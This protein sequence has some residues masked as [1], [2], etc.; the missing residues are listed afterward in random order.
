MYTS[1][2]E[3]DDYTDRVSNETLT[4]GTTVPLAQFY[5]RDDV[6][7]WTDLTTQEAY[8]AF[9]AGLDVRRADVTIGAEIENIQ[10]L[11]DSSYTPCIITSEEG[12]RNMGLFGEKLEKAEIYL[13]GTPD[14]ETEAWL[15]TRISS[16]ASRGGMTVTNNLAYRRE[17]EASQMS[18]IVVF[19]CIAVV[20]FAAAA[21]MICGNVSRQIRADSRMIGTLRAVGADDRAL[22]GCYSGSILIS[23]G[24]GLVTAVLIM[25]AMIAL[26]W[27]PSPNEQN[28]VPAIISS[29][30]L[31]ALMLGCCQWVLR[32]RVKDVIKKSIV[33]NIKEL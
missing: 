2:Y 31:A 22:A 16:I 33:E 13:A 10:W 8:D 29:L 18:V 17:Q 9:Y 14:A 15:E 30:C 28:F 5:V 6:G 12:L 24:L 4:V 25:I 3:G 1:F 27:F 32:L 7:M 19:L 21:G 26:G 11:H 23:I 20:F